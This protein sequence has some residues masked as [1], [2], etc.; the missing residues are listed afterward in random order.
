[1]DEDGVWSVARRARKGHLVLFYRVLPEGFVADI[2]LVAGEVTN[3]EAGWKEGTDWMAPI[4]RVCRLANPLQYKTMI[5]RSLERFFSDE[6]P[7]AGTPESE[8]LLGRASRDDCGKQ[9]QS[10]LAERCVRPTQTREGLNLKLSVREMTRFG[11]SGS[12]GSTPF[13]VS[14]ENNIR[15]VRC[16]WFEAFMFSGR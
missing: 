13:S 11:C 4:T 15:N 7:I 12:I 10:R 9:F 2:F 6:R 1:M 14:Q 3:E 8:R 5:G 16:Y